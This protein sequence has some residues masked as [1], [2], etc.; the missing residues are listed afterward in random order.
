MARF[1]KSFVRGDDHVFRFQVV[2][3][4][5]LVA[6]DTSA[7]TEFWVTSKY[8]LDSADPGEVVLTLG[9]GI[10]ALDETVGLYEFTYARA[11][12]EALTDRAL[13]METD[14]QGKTDLAKIHTLA[15][16]LMLVLPQAEGRS[17]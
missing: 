11:L 9:D 16:G 12:S 4:D 7:W 13:S 14:I 5:T 2:D 6:Q 17:S 8:R 3:S 15:Q 1:I 10:A